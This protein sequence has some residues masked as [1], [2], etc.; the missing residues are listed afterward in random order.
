MTAAARPLT[1]LVA[2]WYALELSIDGTRLEPAAPT[3]PAMIFGHRIRM[4]L[5]PFDYLA[6][7][8]SLASDWPNPG[9]PCS[10]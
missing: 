1:L 3:W 2:S 8:E 10:A 5:E 9:D 4:R 6:V 7:L